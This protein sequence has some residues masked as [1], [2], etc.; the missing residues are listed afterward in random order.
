MP[1]AERMFELLENVSTAL[2]LNEGLPAHIDRMPTT[3]RMFE[4][5]QNMSTAVTLKCSPMD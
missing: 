1:T 2:T 5:L 4:L 3:A